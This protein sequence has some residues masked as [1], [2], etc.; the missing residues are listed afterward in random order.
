MVKKAD[1]KRSYI[2]I[3][4]RG[5]KV[6]EHTACRTLSIAKGDGMDMWCA[7]NRATVT[8]YSFSGANPKALVEVGTIGRNGY[9]E[10]KFFKSV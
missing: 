9:N 10:L 3:A 1:S 5:A 4:R 7:Y 2:V 8:I 6:V